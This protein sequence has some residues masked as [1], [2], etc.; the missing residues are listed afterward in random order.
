LF[1]KTIKYKQSKDGAKMT[2]HGITLQ[3]NKTSGI[4]IS[5][6]R[7]DMVEK[8]QRM[9]AKT[10]ETPFGETVIPFGQEGDIGDEVMTNIMQQIF[11]LLRSTKQCIVQ[12]LNDIDCPIDIVTGSA[13]DMYAATVPLQDIFYQYKD[14]DGGQLFDAIEKTNKGMTY[15]FLFH[16]NKIDIFDNML[17]NLDATLDAFGA[18][19]D[20]DVHF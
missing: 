20:C 19:D 14:D 9:T 7:A 12:K 16:E 11:L 17:S 3:V 15:I 5:D 2:T 13:E 10:G 6:F 18:W 1:P 4:T 8:W